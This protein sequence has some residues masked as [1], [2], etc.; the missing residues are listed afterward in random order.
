MKQDEIDV[1]AYMNHVRCE[2]GTC[3]EC[4]EY[5]A[6]GGHSEARK[7]IFLCVRHAMPPWGEIVRGLRRAK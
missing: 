2:Y 4:P 7:L 3:T 1:V 5:K 6:L